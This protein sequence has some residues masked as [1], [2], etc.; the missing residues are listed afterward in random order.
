MHGPITDVSAVLHCPQNKQVRVSLDNTH[1]TSASLPIK[2]LC[3]FIF[4]I[5]ETIKSQKAQPCLTKELQSCS[6]VDCSVESWEAQGLQAETGKDR[7]AQARKAGD[8][9]STRMQRVS[10]ETPSSFLGQ[11]PDADTSELAL[12]VNSA[13][14]ISA[15]VKG[16]LQCHDAK[17]TGLLGGS[18][19]EGGV[20]AS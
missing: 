19:R 10:C 11:R 4:Y 9:A 8:A 7:R 1:K 16:M 14:C 3:H 5:L 20:D 6:Q 2:L 12:S 17:H 18:P 13:S 15:F